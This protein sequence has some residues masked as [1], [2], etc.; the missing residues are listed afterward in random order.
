[1]KKTM[2]SCSLLVAFVAVAM[3]AD[4]H[5]A[6]TVPRDVFGVLNGRFTFEGPWEGPWTVTGDLT[7]TLRHLGLTKMYTT[8]T[9]SAEGE[10][11]GGQFKIVA[12]NGDCIQGRYTA[13]A[14]YTSDY[15]Q[16]LGTATLSIDTGTGRF[17]LARGT[18]AAHFLET[19]DDPTWASA[20][21]SWTLE[22]TVH[23]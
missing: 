2:L 17:A 11:S 15:T 12:A 21:V 19:L 14:R 9:T 18:I 13:A 1:M 16:A 5:G 22:G 7:G 8:H 3:A 6:K 23:Y 20:G 10:I 4:S